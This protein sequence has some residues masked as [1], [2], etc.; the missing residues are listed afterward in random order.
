MYEIL[1]Q[2]WKN[3]CQLLMQAYGEECM[4]RTQRYEWFK[5]F[6]EG[7]TSVSEDPRPGRHSTSTDDHHVERVREVIRGNRRFT[8]RESC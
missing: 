8:I 2:T 4:S 5:S 3:V 6:N 1:L 7:R